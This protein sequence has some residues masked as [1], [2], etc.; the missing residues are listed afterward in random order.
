MSY[1]FADLFCGCGGMSL[2]LIDAGFKDVIAA[3]FWDVA[4]KN[5]LSYHKLAD[6][7]FYQTNMFNEEERMDLKERI[8]EANIDLLAG[9]PP[10]QGFSTLGKR[11][12]KDTRNT[13]VEAYLEMAISIKPKMLIM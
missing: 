1:K 13:L 9:G 12:E 8:K 4:K 7:N 6:A 10:C 5:Y 2:G 11:E 3:D